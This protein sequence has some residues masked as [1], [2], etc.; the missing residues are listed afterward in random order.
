MAKSSSIINEL[1]FKQLDNLVAIGALCVPIRSLNGVPFD[2]LPWFE[3]WAI[4][5]G[6]R[7]AEHMRLAAEAEA[8]ETPRR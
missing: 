6:R 8:S 1:E 4:D 3:L 2:D 5:M 7:E